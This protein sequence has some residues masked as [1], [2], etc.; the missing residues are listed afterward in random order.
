MPVSILSLSRSLAQCFAWSRSSMSTF[1]LDNWGSELCVELLALPLR[2]YPP[3]AVGEEEEG[4]RR[5]GD[6]GL[7]DKEWAQRRLG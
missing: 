1:R 6:S 7:L 2:L 5:L 3:G 4:V